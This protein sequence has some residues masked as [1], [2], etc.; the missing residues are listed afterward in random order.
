MIKRN[1]I[2]FRIIHTITVFTQLLVEK[3]I[4]LIYQI[5][6]HLRHHV[7]LLGAALGD[8]QRQGDQYIVVHKARTIS[9]MR[10]RPP[11]VW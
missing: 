4:I 8:H 10:I 7:L 9:A 11:K 5:H 3:L 1:P 6:H 2:K